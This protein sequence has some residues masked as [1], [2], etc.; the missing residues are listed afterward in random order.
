MGFWRNLFAAGT[1]KESSSDPRVDAAAPPDQR[2]MPLSGSNVP[3]TVTVTIAFLPDRVAYELDRADGTSHQQ[4]IMKPSPPSIAGK[5]MR[6]EFRDMTMRGD[7]DPDE[8]LIGAALDLQA[9]L[10]RIGD[11]DS[12]E[13]SDVAVKIAEW[14][15][16]KCLRPGDSPSIQLRIVNVS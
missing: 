4:G 11:V 2:R 10:I 6:F 16:G 7:V 14:L 12:S 13:A 1:K 3:S 9:K 15:L 5:G 8:V